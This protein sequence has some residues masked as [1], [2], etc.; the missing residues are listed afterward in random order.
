MDSVFNR[1]SLGG[2]EVGTAVLEDLNLFFPFEEE[3]T[4]DRI[5]LC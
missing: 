3:E 2:D 4:D 5:H 1:D